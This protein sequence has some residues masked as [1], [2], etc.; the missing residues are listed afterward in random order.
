[1]D[2]R[3]TRKKQRLTGYDYAGDGAYFVTICTKNR[4]C[5]FWKPDVGAIIDR[6]SVETALSREGKIVAQTITE[7]PIHYPSVSVDNYIMYQDCPSAVHQIVING[8]MIENGIITT[9]YYLDPSYTRQD[10]TYGALKKCNMDELWNA[11]IQ[12]KEPGYVY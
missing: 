6:P 7:I 3:R 1:M 11:M 8:A 9:I 12:N 4:I 5:L 2:T 10:E